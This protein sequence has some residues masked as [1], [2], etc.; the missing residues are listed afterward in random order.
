[1]SWVCVCA[2][3]PSHSEVLGNAFEE[4]QLNR[5]SAQCFVFAF[6]G[7]VLGRSFSWV[8]LYFI[9]NLLQ[10]GGYAISGMLFC[11]CILFDVHFRECIFCMFWTFGAAFLYTCGGAFFIL[12]IF[13]YIISKIM[14]KRY[15]TNACLTPGQYMSKLQFQKKTPAGNMQNPS[16]HK[17]LKKCAS[18][19]TWSAQCKINANLRQM[20]VSL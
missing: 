11:F 17:V 13:F 3:H 7:R 15:K 18:D 16:V 8:E 6:D 14:Q 1:M 4:P 20:R 2:G 5:K 12:F 9:C 19:M 10:L